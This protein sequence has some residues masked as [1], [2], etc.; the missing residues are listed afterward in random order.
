MSRHNVVRRYKLFL[1][2][3][4]GKGIIEKEEDEDRANTQVDVIKLLR[5]CRQVITMIMENV[6]HRTL[7]RPS[8]SAGRLPRVCLV[9]R[10]KGLY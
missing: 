6:Y 8:G 5:E 1:R 9:S 10:A 4:K 2:W 7:A 3:A